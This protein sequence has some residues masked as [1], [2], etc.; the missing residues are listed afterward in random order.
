MGPLSESS[1]ASEI[2]ARP[3]KSSVSGTVF[4]QRAV[5]TDWH[6][7]C[8]LGEG[9]TL[10]M[11]M[12]MAHLFLRGPHSFLKTPHLSQ[13]Y[14][15]LEFPLMFQHNSTHLPRA[16]GASLVAQLVKNLPAMQETLVQFLGLEDPLE[17]G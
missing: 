7:V 4:F 11:V 16:A 10:E 17:K 2:N 14:K 8:A 6:A 5:G 3:L 15:N 12:H 1:R 13:N 9:R